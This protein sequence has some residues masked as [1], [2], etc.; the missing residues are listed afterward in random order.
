MDS[1]LIALC[2]QE[3]SARFTSRTESPNL[4]PGSCPQLAELARDVFNS[5][6][7][8]ERDL[9][10][11]V[12]FAAQRAEGSGQFTESD[13]RA[14]LRGALAFIMCN[15]VPD[16]HDTYLVK[17]GNPAVAFTG[18]FTKKFR[19]TWAFMEYKRA[20]GFDP[21]LSYTYKSGQNARR[22]FQEALVDALR[23]ALQSW[24]AFR[25]YAVASRETQRVVLRPAGN[26]EWG[27][28]PETAGTG[29]YFDR[30]E[31]ISETVPDGTILPQDA[32]FTKTWLLRNAGNVPWVNRSIQRLTPLTI[33]Y[34]HSA[35]IIPIPDTMPDKVATISVRLRAPSLPGFSEVRFKMIHENG[36]FCWPELYTSGLIL[37]IEVQ[38]R[39]RFHQQS[40][41][42]ACRYEGEPGR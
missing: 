39:A 42:L 5:T 3:L 15:V 19:D 28:D 31:F 41:D 9:N 25:H 16:D 24:E 11:L 40:E 8:N 32:E 7:A 36:D 13:R 26:P 1:A 29:S 37:A 18:R 38:S 23:E 2:C 20:Q 12:Y 35:M 14:R 27:A 30:N 21:H 22:F 6:M 10:D 33:Y 34:P 4:L 17:L